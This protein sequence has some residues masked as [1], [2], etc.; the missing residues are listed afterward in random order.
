MRTRLDVLI[1]ALAI[2]AVGALLGQFMFI[3]FVLA[4]HDARACIVFLVFVSWLSRVPGMAIASDLKWDFGHRENTHD[5]RLRA[6]KP[7][8]E[9]EYTQM[10]DLRRVDPAGELRR[11]AA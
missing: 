3:L 6:E 4:H 8:V 9:P 2:L 7:E 10:R 11:E 5:M 1:D